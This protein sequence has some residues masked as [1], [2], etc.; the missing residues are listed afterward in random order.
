MAAAA[1]G[2][3][4]AVNHPDQDAKRFVIGYLQSTYKVISETEAVRPSSKKRYAEADIIKDLQTT[5]SSELKACVEQIP[6]ITLNKLVRRWLTVDFANSKKVKLTEAIVPKVARQAKEFYDHLKIVNNK[7]S[8]VPMLFVRD[9]GTPNVFRFAG[10]PEKEKIMILC[11]ERPDYKEKREHYYKHI[12]E[13]WSQETLE[14]ILE[15]G[16]EVPDFQNWILLQFEAWRWDP[17][18]LLSEAPVPITYDIKEPAFYWVDKDRIKNSDGVCS[19]WDGWMLKI[20]VDFRDVFKAWIFSVFDPQNK[21]RQSLWVKSQGY[22][23]KGKI[24]GALQ[25]HLKGMMGAI[26]AGVLD[27]QFFFSTVY[28]KQLI[29]HDDNK[30]PTILMKGKLHS[31]LGDGLVQME[32]KFENSVSIRMH[33]RIMIFS[34]VPPHVNISRRHETSRIIYIPLE[35]TPEMERAWI[36]E[37]GAL[38]GDNTFEQKL[39]DEF[40]SFIKSCVEPYKR[41]CPHRSEITLTPEL[42]DKMFGVI[43]SE[44]HENFEHMF[45]KVFVVEPNNKNLFMP[46]KELHDAIRSNIQNKDYFTL[47]NALGFL[48]NCYGIKRVQQR[49]GEDRLRGYY[50][51]ALKKNIKPAK[52]ERRF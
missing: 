43:A 6:P 27:S 50:G 41:L 7:E 48:E 51:I 52:I 28:N 32:R 15:K 40:W 46:A 49:I 8:T 42:R 45:K 26:S 35:T 13:Y 10:E 23:G 25:Y 11:Q 5:G 34:N 37:D 16:D 38:L 9:S 21:G 20:P 29:L 1:A 22:D 47:D 2:N 4:A 24:S 39:K 36:R 30:D 14:A 3:E 17:D 44:E 18:T 12:D 19:T 31:L 33:A